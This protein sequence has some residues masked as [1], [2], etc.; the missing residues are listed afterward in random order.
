MSLRL[1]ILDQLRG[2]VFHVT[3]ENSLSSIRQQGYI[4]T[5]ETGLLDTPFGFPSSYGRRKGYVCLF[6]LRGK[7]D[8]DIQF[9]HDCLC[10]THPS[11]LGAHI[12]YLL[13]SGAAHC[14]IIT[15]SEAKRDVGPH[16][17]WDWVPRLEC[18]FPRDLPFDSIKSIL[19]ADFGTGT[20]TIERLANQQV[21][22]TQ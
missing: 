7:S 8:A 22:R 21:H 11:A 2:N 14:E 12:A 10:F 15:E 1:N 16:G 19:H 20:L 4:A 17:S 5:N 18:W 3:S 9:G 6:D 13:L